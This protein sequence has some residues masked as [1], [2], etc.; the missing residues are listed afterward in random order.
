M[1]DD[2]TLGGWTSLDWM[3]KED[4]FDEVIFAQIHEK[5]EEQAM[6]ESVG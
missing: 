1:Q 4:F 5:E 6:G 2:W 3:S